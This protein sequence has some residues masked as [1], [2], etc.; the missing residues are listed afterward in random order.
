[1]GSS[2]SL[3]VLAIFVSGANAENGLIK[4]SQPVVWQRLDSEWV[5]FTLELLDEEPSPGEKHG[6]AQIRIDKNHDRPID[7]R[8]D[9]MYAFTKK[10]KICAMYVLKK[11][12]THSLRWVQITGA[13]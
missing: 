7:S 5:T 2:V 13:D 11:Y 4:N 8:V 9:V 3:I 1:M 12:T 10:D 6:Y